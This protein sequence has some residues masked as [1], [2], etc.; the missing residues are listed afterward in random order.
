[1]RLRGIRGGATLQL[2]QG[3]AVFITGGA[4][5]ERGKASAVDR[6]AERDDANTKQ[7]QQLPD[8]DHGALILLRPT[9]AKG[10][11]GVKWFK[12]VA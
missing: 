12:L 3:G 11:P 1:M 9:F 6:E 5:G 8:R 7:Q 4:G 2:P 10:E